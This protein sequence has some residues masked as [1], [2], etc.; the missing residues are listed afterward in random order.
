MGVTQL[1][2][3]ALALG[4]AGLERHGI[5]IERDFKDTSTITVDKHKSLEIL[6]NLLSNAKQAIQSHKGSE[7]KLT[8]RTIT[9]SGGMV[10]ISV[11]DTGVG[12]SPENL[13]RVFAHGFTTKKEGHGFGLHSAANG[14]QTLG[15]RLHAT[16][17]GLGFG[18]CFT[19][20]LPLD[21]PKPP[22]SESNSNTRHPQ[23]WS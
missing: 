4:M 20:T 6:I 1:V 5:L 19:L 23:T 3:E 11:I 7:R 13:Q 18:A 15:G 9:G 21:A 2:E 22:T 14:A 10:E 8:V 12:I 17:K 16:S